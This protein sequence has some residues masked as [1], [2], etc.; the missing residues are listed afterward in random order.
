MDDGAHLPRWRGMLFVV[1]P[2]LVAFAGC[3][4]LLLAWRKDPKLRHEA[5]LA[6]AILRRNLAIGLLITATLL[7]GAIPILAVT[8]VITD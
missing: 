1:L 7:A 5:M 3:A 8:H 2:G 6:L 4:I